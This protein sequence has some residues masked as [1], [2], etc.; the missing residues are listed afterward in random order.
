MATVNNIPDGNIDFVWGPETVLGLIF[1]V[2]MILLFIL[3]LMEQGIFLR[4]LKYFFLFPV[5][6]CGGMMMAALIAPLMIGLS[7]M[8]FWVIFSIPVLGVP[9]GILFVCVATYTSLDIIRSQD[10][11]EM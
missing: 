10:R 1:V 11:G 7:I 4:F 8:A 6:L 9:I 5:Y 3:K 2:S